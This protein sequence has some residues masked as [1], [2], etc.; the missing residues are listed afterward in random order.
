MKKTYLII[1]LLFSQLSMLMGQAE[2]VKIGAY[3]SSIYDFDISKN[4]IGADI[5]FWCIY[6]NPDFNF[7]NEL[8]FIDCS[9]IEKS[10]T[11]VEDIGKKKWFYTKTK[12]NSRQKYNT[13]NYPFDKQK[14]AFQVESSEFATDELIFVP[15]RRNSKIAPKV[16][17]EF[18]EWEIIKT[19]FHVGETNYQ[20]SFGDPESESTQSSRFEIEM[21]IE[22]LDSMLILFKL[23]TGI[24]VAF[25]ISSCVFWIKPI[26]TDPRFGLCVG[27]LFAAIGNK[28]IVES[29][30]PS[31]NEVTLLDNLH[32]ITFV[33]IFII[34][35]ISV[36]SLNIYE[37][38][39]EKSMKL[40]RRI[41]VISFASIVSVYMILLF[42]SINQTLHSH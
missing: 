2:M 39:T 31:T 5:H 26:N 9:E 29:I 40:S 22:R 18:S 4:S 37:R 38:D 8:E 41:D 10:G 30:V 14:I 42:T 1:V 6:Q 19:D 13:R 21:D 3:V 15:D 20:T 25:L 7:D 24:L 11:S 17:D 36:I 35:I 32:N 27:G 23:I 12:L 16:K 33:A 34:I 28:Y